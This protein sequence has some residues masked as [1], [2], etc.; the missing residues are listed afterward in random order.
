MVNTGFESYAGTRK[1]PWDT[2]GTVVENAMTAEEALRLAHL[3][4][5]NVRKTPLSTIVGGRTLVVPDQFAMV[6]DNPFTG[7]PEAFAGVNGKLFTPVQNEEHAEFLNTLTDTSGA[8]IEAAGSLEG[9]RRVY[10]TMKFPESVSIAGIDTVDTYLT[11]FNS[12]D[13]NS[14]FQVIVSPVRLA[15]KN[16]IHAMLKGAARSA[17]VRH[18]AGHGG[19]IARVRE[20]LGLTFSYMEAFEEEAQKMIDRE[21]T[22][23]RFGG[24]IANLYPTTDAQSDLVNNRAREH[25][26]NIRDLFDNSATLAG[27]EGTAWAGYNAVTEYIDHFVAVRG[28]EDFEVAAEKRALFNFNGRTD[29]LK[30][31]AFRLF[32][33]A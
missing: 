9:G 24:I 28:T 30:E 25:R 31:N 26:A 27:I 33:N 17:K 18:T 13:G 20:T 11:A 15:C 12:H 8:H 4:D 5:W 19:A 21:I 22:S 32:A 29:A 14:A 10:V 2:L 23:Q 3:A 7:E 1:L 16:Q 6:R